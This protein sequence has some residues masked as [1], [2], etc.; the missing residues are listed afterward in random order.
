MSSSRS[1]SGE[2][3]AGRPRHWA[4]ALS[5]VLVAGLLVLAVGLLLG[6]AVAAAAGEPGP[7]PLML[8]GHTVGAVVAV[9]LHRTALR[10][11]GTLGYAAVFGVAGVLAL[12][13]LLFWWN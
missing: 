7:G 9:V 5:G 12:L 1:H 4:R 10:R 11:T 3:S 2:G 8:I 13:G 6:W